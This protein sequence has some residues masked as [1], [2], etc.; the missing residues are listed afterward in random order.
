MIM[1][2]ECKAAAVE[3]KDLDARKHVLGSHSSL[4][5]KFVLVI[6]GYTAFAAQ[7]WFVD[8]TQ[9]G[10]K[11]KD[12]GS[13]TPLRF[14]RPGQPSEFEDRSCTPTIIKTILPFDEQLRE[15]LKRYAS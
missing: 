10:I 6:P 9:F 4:L 11:A 7:P 8:L 1:H 5:A 13:E 14:T 2:L 12:S 3:K 15:L